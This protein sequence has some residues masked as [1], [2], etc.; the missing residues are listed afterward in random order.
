MSLSQ[1]ISSRNIHL[2]IPDY[3]DFSNKPGLQM[4]VKV[5]QH[6]SPWHSPWWWPNLTSILY[7]GC[8]C[9][10]SRHQSPGS[11]ASATMVVIM[12]LTALNNI[13]LWTF[14]LLNRN[15]LGL[16][17]Q[18]LLISSVAWLQDICSHWNDHAIYDLYNAMISPSYFW[19]R[20]LVQ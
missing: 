13:E 14:D 5:S 16:L 9:P 8:W 2:I 10:G 20:N 6:R 12:L 4:G 17:G 15:N 7:S 19:N 1:G 3:S 11:K 18:W